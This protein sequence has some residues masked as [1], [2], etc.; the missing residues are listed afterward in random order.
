MTG[1]ISNTQLQVYSQSV[2]IA[3][4]QK[5]YKIYKTKYANIQNITDVKIV[6]QKALV[7][8]HFT[9]EV[10][11]GNT[12]WRRQFCRNPNRNKDR[13]ASKQIMNRQRI[14]AMRGLFENETRETA[15]VLEIFQKE[16]SWA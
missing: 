7:N 14:S 4:A 2:T 3:T 6:I 8:L 11:L 13:L 1:P 10:P 15:T 5:I 16:V 9:I 12:Q